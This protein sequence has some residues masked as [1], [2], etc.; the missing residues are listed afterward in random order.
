[1]PFLYFSVPTNSTGLGLE[2]EP[3]YRNSIPFTCIYVNFTYNYYSTLLIKMIV[4][5]DVC[6]EARNKAQ[7][8]VA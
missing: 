7:P 8:Y 3:K 2:P 5:S 1:M 4:Y 6:A